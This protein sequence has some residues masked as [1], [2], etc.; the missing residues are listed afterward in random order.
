[1]RKIDEI[2]LN[3]SKPFNDFG[4]TWNNGVCAVYV[5]G[6]DLLERESNS[7][8]WGIPFLLSEKRHKNVPYL[9]F[10]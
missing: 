2:N 4:Y 10:R 7:N 8:L 6:K 3:R 1:M 9:D 5:T